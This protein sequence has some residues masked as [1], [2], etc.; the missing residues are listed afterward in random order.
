MK[1]TIESTTQIVMLDGAPTRVW[2]G[3]TESGIRVNCFIKRV[4][5]QFAN[6]AEGAQFECELEE[7]RPPSA[8]VDAI[9]IDRQKES[10]LQRCAKERWKSVGFIIPMELDLDSALAIIGNMQVALR[11][12]LNNGTAAET[13]RSAVDGMIGRMLEAGLTA[14]A[15]LARLGDDPSWDEKR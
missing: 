7:T 15:E 12:P 13:A 3:A 4:Q 11:H 10:L 9:P 8:K 6:A 2:E 14:H 1:V 5:A